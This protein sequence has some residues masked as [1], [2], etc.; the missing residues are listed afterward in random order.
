MKDYKIYNMSS[1]Q[2]T[3]NRVLFNIHLS[4]SENTGEKIYV[5]NALPPNGIKTFRIKMNDADNWEVEHNN[6]NP[7]WLLT[8]SPIFD[9]AIKK[10]EMGV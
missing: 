4:I 9:K 10:H 7:V 1:F 5:A 2:I 3:L 8:V 6:G